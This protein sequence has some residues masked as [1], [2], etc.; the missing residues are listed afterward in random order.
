MSNIVFDGVDLASEYGLVTPGVAGV[1][2][3]AGAEITRVFVPGSALPSDRLLRRGLVQM[4]FQCVVVGTS[5]DNLVT[6]LRR[7]KAAVSPEK[8]WCSF[9]ITDLSGLRTFARCDGLDIRLDQLPYLD[10]V[11]QFELVFTRYPWWEDETAM[12][13]TNPTS[14]LNSGD[15][16][17]FPVYTCTLSAGMPDGLS[18]TVDS[19][20]FTYA[21]AL[22]AGDALVVDSEAMT[23]E[24]NGSSAL[25]GTD[26]DTEFP[27]LVTGTNAV[28]RSS[29]DFD[30]TVS[31]RRRYE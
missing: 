2:T 22:E 28:S 16:P 21:S 23:V 6:K 19:K 12:E 7:L 30:L 31:Y 25:S 10:V 3:L 8:G 26:A 13:V 15:L 24:L 1:H 17:T 9:T 18:F 14:I 4:R 11:A 27:E 20:T 29:E 5:H